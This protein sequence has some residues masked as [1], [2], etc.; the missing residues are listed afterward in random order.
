MFIDKFKNIKKDN[1]NIIN[2][3]FINEGPRNV[4]HSTDSDIYSGV[5]L[6]HILLHS[7]LIGCV[8]RKKSEQ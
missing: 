6:Q 2:K 3:Y 7:I 1:D 5:Y 8:Y 4:L